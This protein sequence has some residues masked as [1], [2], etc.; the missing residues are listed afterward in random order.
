MNSEIS[1]SDPV[2][3]VSVPGEGFPVQCPNLVGDGGAAD[4]L[5]STAF[6]MGSVAGILKIVLPYL[7]VKKPGFSSPRED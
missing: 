5:M 4:I 3:M 6:L 1:T 2:E 7:P